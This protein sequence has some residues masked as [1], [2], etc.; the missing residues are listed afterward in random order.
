MV[1]EMVGEA[2]DV[3]FYQALDP[4]DGRRRITDVIEVLKPG[5]ANNPF[6]SVEFQ[7]RQLV[8]WIPRLA[9]RWWTARRWIHL[10]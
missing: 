1:A 5:V 4:E 10:R 6:G 8:R 3:V 7:V 2:I 9:M